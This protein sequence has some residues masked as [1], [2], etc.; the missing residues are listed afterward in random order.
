MTPQCLM[1]IMTVIMTQLYRTKNDGYSATKKPQGFFENHP[2][3]SHAL[4][5]A[6]GSIRLLLTKNHPVS[7]HA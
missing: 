6:G 3:T 1:I 4:G 2:M 7:S 5:A